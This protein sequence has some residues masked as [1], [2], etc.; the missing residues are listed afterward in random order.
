MIDGRTPNEIARDD[1]RAGGVIRYRAMDTSLGRWTRTDPLGYADGLNAFQAVRSSPVNLLDPLG[2]QSTGPTSQP[3]PQLP[4]PILIPMGEATADFPN[5]NP[6]DP[7]ANYYVVPATIP[8]GGMTP[9]T[10]FMWANRMKCDCDESLIQLIDVAPTRYFDA[11]GRDFTG[12]LRNP[13]PGRTYAEGF[14]LKDGITIRQDTHWARR[15]FLGGADR[16]QYR[17]KITACCG[18]YDG[19]NVNNDEDYQQ[20]ENAD[21]AKIKCSGP[22]F[23]MNVEFNSYRDGRW[24]L[25]VPEVGI[26]G[27]R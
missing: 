26:D 25:K 12:E 9:Q 14:E 8:P 16:I 5:V 20:W 7:D 6:A 22:T 17:V 11:Q 2:L 19:Q 10:F 24:S 27:A 4:Q 13:V 15:Q 18:T 3:H 23:V 21:P 1:G